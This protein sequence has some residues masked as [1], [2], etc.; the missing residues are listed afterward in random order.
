MK[1]NEILSQIES[2]AHSQGFYGRFLRQLLDCKKNDPESW[3]EIVEELEAQ[4]FKDPVDMIIY[5][6]S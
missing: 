4:N 5:F 3:Q 6:E 1:I 2:L